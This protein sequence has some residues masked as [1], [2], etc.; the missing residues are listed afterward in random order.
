MYAAMKIDRY[1]IGL[2]QNPELEA[3]IQKLKAEQENRQYA[4]MVKNVNNKVSVTAGDK[5]ISI[6]HLSCRTSDLQFS[7]ILQTHDAR[8]FSRHFGNMTR[9]LELGIFASFYTKLGK[10]H[11][12]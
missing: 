3:R 6:L 5:N 10:K 7:L 8:V 9:P 11:T 2:F 4:D 1:P 12:L